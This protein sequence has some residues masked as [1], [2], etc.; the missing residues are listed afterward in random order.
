MQD[1]KLSVIFEG[2]ISEGKDPQEV[3]SAF[4]EQLHIPA[5]KIDHVFSGARVVLKKGL[6]L[7]TALK[8]QGRLARMGAFCRI[9]PQAPPAEPAAGAPPASQPFLCPKCGQAAPGDDP[10]VQRGE[11][12]VCGIVV[13]KYL[14]GHAED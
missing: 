4:L 14:K 11:C 1:T 13:E 10:S 9:E 3:R 5:A 7:E 8:M 2:R 12:P 6:D